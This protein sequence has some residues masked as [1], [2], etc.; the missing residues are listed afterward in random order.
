VTY[1]DA[2]HLAHA[3]KIRSQ[4]RALLQMIPGLELAPLDESELCC[5]AAGTYNLVQPEMSDRLGTRKVENIEKT[6]AV[7]V[8]AGNV[9][10]ILQMAK[11]VRERGSKVRV[12]HTIDLL[13]MAYTGDPA[14]TNPDHHG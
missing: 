1:H 14:P 8:A 12:V 4:P 5:G 2:C 11:K 9:G 13:D 7:F 10:C 3:Q 6:D